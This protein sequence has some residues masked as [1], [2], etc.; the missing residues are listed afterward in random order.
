MTQSE[1]PDGR[2]SPAAMMPPFLWLWLV[3]Y[4]IEVPSIAQSS[5]ASFADLTGHGDYSAEVATTPSFRMLRVLTLVGLVPSLAVLC[6]AL[7]VAFPTL[8]RWWVERTLELRQDRRPAI[9]EMQ[10]FIDRFAPGL[11][12]RANVLR[13]DRL[14]RV[15][16]VGWRRARIAVFGPMVAL[17]R[18]DRAAAESILLHEIAHYRT[19]DHLIVGLGSPLVGFVNAWIP[20]FALF[21]LVPT[22]LFALIYPIGWLLL[23]QLGLLVTLLPRMLLLPVSGLWLAE[24]S[25]DRYVV[26]SG[27]GSALRRALDAQGSKE[28]RFLAPITDLAHPP[29]AL[30]R[31]SAARRGGSAG[32]VILLAGWPVLQLGLLLVILSS[33]VAGWRLLDYPWSQ[34]TSEAVINSHSFLLDA[35]Q[36]WIPAVLVLLTW[37]IL[38]TLWARWWVGHRPA[39]PGIPAGSYRT[40]AALSAI[41]LAGSLFLTSCGTPG[42]APA[43]EESS[44]P[45]ATST[46]QTSTTQTSTAQARTEPAEPLV[47]DTSTADDPAAEEVISPGDYTVT[48]SGTV[49]GQQFERT[50]EL[51]VLPTVTDYGVTNDVN[52][53]EVCLKS[54]FPAGSPELGAL[55]FGTNTACFPE[56]GAQLDM[57]YV[58]VSGNTVTVEPDSQIAA[59]GLN[60]FVD[61]GDFISACLYYPVSGTMIVTVST[62]GSVSGSLDLVGYSGPCRATGTQSTYRAEFTGS[63]T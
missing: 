57:A 14:V 13:P 22:M 55:W 62:D 49:A 25:A 27:Y 17:W 44:A 54:G 60:S 23:A 36:L 51:Q 3:L 32:S 45:P 46:T 30:R 19:G 33:A 2:L 11:Q 24:L 15:Y 48:L 52:L 58:S 43:P 31:W 38:S 35:A 21:G 59:T 26:E 28:R 37:P 34:I 9:T 53:I 29:V 5:W 56:R 8:R 61:S 4:T 20:I 50:A 10:Q 39:R 16:P 47:E 18:S 42:A 41:L 12:I 40:A 63:R 6:G 1:D 7:A